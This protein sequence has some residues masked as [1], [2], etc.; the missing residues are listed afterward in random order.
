MICDTLQLGGEAERRRG[1]EA[2]RRRD[3]LSPYDHLG[4]S[5]THETI[6]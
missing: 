2:E 3:I 5:A 1:G 6:R 4:L